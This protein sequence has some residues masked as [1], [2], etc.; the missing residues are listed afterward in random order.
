MGVH[1]EA[2]L[3]SGRTFAGPFGLFILERRFDEVKAR[4]DD[5]LAVLFSALRVLH[6][7]VFRSGI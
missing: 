4:R 1:I 6:L 2:F 3:L 7:L 5:L